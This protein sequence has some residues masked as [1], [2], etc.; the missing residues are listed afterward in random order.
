MS[1][2][3]S[4]AKA[5]RRAAVRATRA[6]SVRNTQPWRFVLRPDSLEI[7]VDR[8]R[9]LS[10]LDSR[11]RQMLISCGCAVFNARVSMA[12]SGVATHVEYFAD[13]ERSPLLA[14][15]SAATLDPAGGSTIATGIDHLD[16]SIEVRQTNRREFTDQLVPPTL[17]DILVA[18]AA[19]EGCELIPVV[20]D[21]HKQTLAELGELAERTASADPALAAEIRRWTSDDPGRVDGVPSLGADHASIDPVPAAHRTLFLL[22]TTDDGPAAWLRTGQALQRVLLEVTRAGYA[23]R[24]MIAHVEVARTYEALRRQLDLTIHPHLVLRGGLAQSHPATRR[25]RL[26]DVIVDHS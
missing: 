5:L 4:V 9:H 19:A 13:P 16:V 1:I 12:A 6:P 22:A 18:A 25:R 24:P 15:L 14:R 23:A 20:R 17:R 7:H 3:P 21:E 11:G 10:V 2:D 26:I 8:T